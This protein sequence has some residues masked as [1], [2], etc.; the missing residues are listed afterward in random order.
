VEESEG[1]EPLLRYDAE[2]P[3]LS[4]ELPF[5]LPAAVLIF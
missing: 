3:L 2:I 4:D 1:K 5:F